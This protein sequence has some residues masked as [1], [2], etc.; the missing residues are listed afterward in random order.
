M[1]RER[2]RASLSREEKREE[3]GLPLVE[4]REEKREETGLP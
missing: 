3:R 2:R 1:R 4:K